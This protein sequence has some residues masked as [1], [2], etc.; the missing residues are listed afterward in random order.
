[1]MRMPSEAVP[2]VS[3]ASPDAHDLIGIL[4]A[5]QE[6]AYRWDFVT[7][8]ITWESNAATVLQIPHD[9]AITTGA[10]FLRLIAPEHV[11]LR[12][13]AIAGAHTPEV[14]E[15][16]AYRV[17]YPFAPPGRSADGCIWLEDHGHW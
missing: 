11:A 12:H 14:G 16:M 5:V 15:S 2:S 1:M 17:Q 6:T 4:S 8:Q 13:A 10:A 3:Q 9:Q 7:D